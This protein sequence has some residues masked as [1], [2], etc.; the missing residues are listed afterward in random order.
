VNT[1]AEPASAIAI[2]S[3]FAIAR[4]LGPSSPSTIWTT[5]EISSPA[6][7]AM[8]ATA[9][10][11]SR[12][13]RS[14]GSSA[15]ANTGSAMN[16]TTSVVTVIPSCAPDR[17]N[18]SRRWTAT[19]RAALRSPSAASSSSRVRRAATNENSAATK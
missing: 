18:E 10:S 5:V 3:G 11:G 6:V 15:A 12:N 9:A 1:A 13:G 17:T 4:F 8:L 16:P 2:G 19:A 7:S 14:S